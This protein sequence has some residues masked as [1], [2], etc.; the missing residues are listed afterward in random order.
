[1][2]R[3]L[4]HLPFIEE[5]IWTANKAKNKYTYY[6]KSRK[7]VKRNQEYCLFHRRVFPQYTEIDHINRNGLDNR[8]VNIRERSWKS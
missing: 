3:D 1:M 5:R 8:A 7:S 6:V 2:M 4:E